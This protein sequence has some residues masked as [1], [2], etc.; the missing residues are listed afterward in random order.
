MM[1]LP[2]PYA[3]SIYQYT[4]YIIHGIYYNTCDYIITSTHVICYNQLDLQTKQRAL[5]DPSGPL[6]LSSVIV[7]GRCMCSRTRAMSDPKGIGNVLREGI[8]CSSLWQPDSKIPG[9][10]FW[11]RR[12][13]SQDG[14]GQDS[15][16]KNYRH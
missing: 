3:C 13:C 10:S 12:P 8:V 7:N 5:P 9:S 16:S 14:K 15:A 1:S 11:L 6:P 2:I 4:G